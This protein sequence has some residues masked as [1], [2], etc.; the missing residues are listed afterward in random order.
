MAT[1]TRCVHILTNDAYTLRGFSLAFQNLM[2][3]SRHS[4]NRIQNGV[5]FTTGGETNITTETPIRWKMRTSDGE[6][7]RVSHPWCS[8]KFSLVVVA[9]VVHD[10]D[11]VVRSSV[12]AGV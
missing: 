3:E 9:S 1:L 6:G 7:T 4:H 11:V 10:V 5:R 2:Q 12:C 8:H